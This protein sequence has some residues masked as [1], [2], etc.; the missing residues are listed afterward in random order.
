MARI[1]ERNQPFAFSSPDTEAV[2]PAP[3]PR[4][5]PKAGLAVVAFALVLSVFWMGIGAAYLWGYFGL[6]GLA[7]LSVQQMALFAAAA[8]LPPLLF[9]AAAWALARGQAMRVTAQ[10]MLEATDRLFAAD[11]T[12]ARTA[13]Q[14]GRAVR[15]ELDALNAGLDG[16]FS[17]LR[18]LETVLEKQ[19]AALDEAGARAQVRGEAIATH[20]TQEAK[21]IENIC[22]HISDAAG[23]AGETMAGRAA[24]LKTTIESAEGALK[25]A[26]QAL[27]VQIAGFRASADAAVEAP[28][29]AAIELDKQAKRIE[30]VSDAAMARAEFVL[31][32]HEKHR[33]AMGDL[34][35]RLKDDSAAFE[36]ALGQQRL[37]MEQAVSALSGEAQKFESL[38]GDAERHLELIMA[39]AAAR[40]AQLTTSFGREAERLKESS[41]NA[42]TV[43][44]NLIAA[45]REAGTGAQTLIG[46]SAAQAKLDAK[47]LVGEAMGECEKLLRVA[48]TLSERASQ[49]RAELAGT[50]QDVE[51][52][53][54]TLPDIA[55]QEAQRVRQMVRAETEQILDLSARTLSTIHARSAITREPQQNV[56][57]IGDLPMDS[58]GDGLRGLA[59]KLTQRPK[60]KGDSAD[61]KNWEM[62]TLL[63][64]AEN[65]AQTQP[66]FRPGNVAALG[67]LEAALADM[68]VDLEAITGD[69]TPG[70]EDW[71]RYLA[72]DRA[73]FA[74]KLAETI[75]DDTVNRI[76]RLYRENPRFREA[77]DGYLS[78]FETLLA[79]AREGDGGGILTSTILSADTGKIY[80]AVAYALGRL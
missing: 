1:P 21:R 32:R 65:G 54:L 8:V 58:D 18:A 62:R 17:R 43:L 6:T 47:A 29:A 72:G 51:H 25:M 39:N 26:G 28:H 76:S 19:I 41:E 69:A 77:A 52:H 78:E 30:T 35:Q 49:I 61:P 66:S 27:D 12:A 24:Q 22:D 46:E 34:L 36:A 60:R 53:L 55:Q 57:G 5:A 73:V 7:A 64:A 9:I 31:G 40:A 37:G 75:D 74:R 42:N 68:A 59:R 4:P 50:V 56:S 45:L 11:E 16:A 44:G 79:H 3:A 2:L 67:A 10:A 48:G 14:L 70:E 23:R 63:A 13:A 15:R 80:L 20:L 71:R 33:T 38:T